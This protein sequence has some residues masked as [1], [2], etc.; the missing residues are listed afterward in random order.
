MSKAVYGDK[1]NLGNWQR[2]GQPNIGSQGFLGQL[3]EKIINGNVLG[4]TYAFAGTQDLKADGVQDLLQLIGLSAQ[5]N[6]AYNKGIKLSNFFK[7]LSLTFTG[8]SLGGGL[9]ALAALVTGRPAITFNAA[10]L[11]NATLE[12]YGVSDVSQNNIAAYS[13]PLDPLTIEQNWNPMLNSAQGTHYTIP[14]YDITYKIWENHMINT[15][16]EGLK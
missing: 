15:V 8:H 13:T 5:Y 6:Q 14:I 1:V 11:S 16:I 7:N 3:Y 10:S 12:K 4:Y 9:A 2:V